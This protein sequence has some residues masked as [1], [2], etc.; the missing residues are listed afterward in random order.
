METGRKFWIT[1][2]GMALVSG[3]SG[4]ALFRALAMPDGAF[5]AIA[6]M[7]GA[8]CGANAAATYAYS[9]SATQSDVTDRKITQAITERR[10]PASGIEPTS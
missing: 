3:L 2:V 4:Y 10:D 9:K 5:S 7:V 8:F 1:F 6:F